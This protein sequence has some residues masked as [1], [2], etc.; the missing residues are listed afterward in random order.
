[1][2][3]VIIES[4]PVPI[5]LGFGFGTAL[6][7]G[8]GRRGPDLGLGLDNWPGIRSVLCKYVSRW[9]MEILLD[10]SQFTFS[11]LLQSWNSYY[12]VLRKNPSFSHYTTNMM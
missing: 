1:M 9:I 3:Y 4:P 2:A 6:G 7:L 5:G 11:C 12:K 8:L 10:F